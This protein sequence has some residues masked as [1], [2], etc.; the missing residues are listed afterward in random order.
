M[1]PRPQ[2]VNR[3]HI[4]FLGGFIPRDS[5]LSAG[6]AFRVSVKV[7]WVFK[8]YIDS[9]VKYTPPFSPF[10]FYVVT[11]HSAAVELALNSGG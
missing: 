5:L 6:A 4:I 8:R 7:W 9:F 1:N 11:S 2:T 3:T 10:L